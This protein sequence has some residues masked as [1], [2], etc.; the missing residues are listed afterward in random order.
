MK[1]GIGMPYIINE[2]TIALLP[3]G[4]KTKIL[5]LGRTLEVKE[6]VMKIIDYNCCLNGST[7]EGRRKGSS[8]LIGASYKPPIIV[9]ELKRI[10]LIPTHSS[11]NPNCSWFI[12]ENISKYYLNEQHQVTVIF[13][14]DQKINL[15][16]CYANFDKQFF[17]AMRLESA[18]RGQKH[19]KNL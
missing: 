7:L 19:T 15:N 1:G 17:R 4:K 2:N 6:T 8:Y 5:E 10:I 12:L 16:L 14:N 11:K 9:N 18:L 13:K 3:L